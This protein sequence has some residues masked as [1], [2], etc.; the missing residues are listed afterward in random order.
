MK[1]NIRVKVYEEDCNYAIP[2]TPKELI[3]YI[4][5]K[6]SLV[7]KEYMD[8]AKIV[9]E[10]NTYYDSASLD[11]I[12]SHMRLETD[13]EEKKRLDREKQQR[14]WRENQ[15]LCTLEKLKEKYGV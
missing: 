9:I 1:N 3:S 2:K 12:V 6:I 7:P 15:E 10:A 5:G 4:K 13:A 14:E 11:I 8:T